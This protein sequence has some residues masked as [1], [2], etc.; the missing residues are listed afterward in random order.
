MEGN[1]LSCNKMFP[2]MDWEIVE[3][4]NSFEMALNESTPWNS[5]TNK[6]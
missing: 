1:D 2:I 4:G 3:V 5:Q 6:R